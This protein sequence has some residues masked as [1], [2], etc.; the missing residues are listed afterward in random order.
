MHPVHVALESPVMMDRLNFPPRSLQ[1]KDVDR[2]L[3]GLSKVLAKGKCVRGGGLFGCHQEAV[4]QAIN[5]PPTIQCRTSFFP[6]SCFWQSYRGDKTSLVEGFVQTT[7]HVSATRPDKSSTINSSNIQSRHE[8]F[9][10][11]FAVGGPA[12][13]YLGYAPGNANSDVLKLYTRRS[14]PCVSRPRLRAVQVLEDEHEPLDAR[15]V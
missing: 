14:I 3:F 10:S 1:G 12:E 2:H 7:H 5:S 15:D 13:H 4:L 8:F 9:T 11:N 6:R